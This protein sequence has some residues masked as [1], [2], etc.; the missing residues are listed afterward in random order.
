MADNVAITAGAG[1]TVGTDE[2]TINSVAVQIQRVDEQAG[3]GWATGQVTPTAT[4]ATLA[5]ARDTRKSILVYNG[6]NMTVFIGPVT[7]TT[8]NGFGIPA[9]ASLEVSTT[10]LLQN[11]VSTVTGLTGVL[12]YSETYDA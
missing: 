12:H 9:G 4:A 11:I 5:A 3:T 6:T 8:G 10:A 7:V 1:T 2:R